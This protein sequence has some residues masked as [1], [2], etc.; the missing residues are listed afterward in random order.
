MCRKKCIVWLLLFAMCQKLFT[1]T[2]SFSF[3]K[4][5]GN[6]LGFALASVGDRKNICQVAEEQATVIWNLIRLFNTA[7]APL[8]FLQAITR[9]DNL[10]P[11]SACL[12]LE[13]KG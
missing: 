10:S 3:F 11:N 12:I 5:L 4:S 2:F 7:C 6:C 8:Y 1:L 9:K 13:Q